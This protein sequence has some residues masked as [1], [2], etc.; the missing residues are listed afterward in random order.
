MYLSIVENLFSLNDP[1]IV[2]VVQ[3]VKDGDYGLGIVRMD[4]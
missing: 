2:F 4:F 1:E 3:V